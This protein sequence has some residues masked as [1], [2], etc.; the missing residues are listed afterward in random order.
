MPHPISIGPAQRCPGRAGPR[1][2][3]LAL[4]ALLLFTASCARGQATAP[5]PPV[6]FPKGDPWL[7][8]PHPLTLAD[9][10]GRI[11]LLDF[12]TPGCINCVQMLPV[13]AR[14]EAAHPHAFTVVEIDSPKFTDSGTLPAL[15][16]FLA[17][18]DVRAPVMLD[19][20]LRL[21]N[22]YG[23][24]AWP[25]Y[26]L[27]GADGHPRVAWLGETPYASLAQ[28]VD[29]QRTQ[30][31]A[32]HRLH[33]RPIRILPPRVPRGLLRWP[34]A[35]AVG[36]GLVAIADTT[37]NRILLLSPRGRLRA[38]IGDG[39]AG[40]RNGAPSVARF[41]HPEGVAFGRKRLYVADTGNN[42]IRTVSLKTLRVRTLAGTGT[43]GYARR[44]HGP[45]RA[46]AL[47]APWG[48]LRKGDALWIAMAGS[49]QVFRL[50]LK[51]D[52]IDLWA[53]DGDE[54]LR[55]G[56]RHRAQ[57]AQPTALAP[58]PG[59]GIF[60]ASPESSSIQELLPQKDQVRT[61]A[62]QGLFSW[63]D[64]D[65]PLA[66]ALFQHPQG[67]ASAGGDLYVADTFNGAIRRIDLR[68]RNVRT[69]ATGLD[70]PEGMAWLRPGVLLIAETG[71]SRLVTLTVANGAVHP[72]PIHGGRR[73]PPEH[74]KR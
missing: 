47:N 16:V 71:A 55:A 7:E 4:A 48:L 39:R 3:P 68:T 64:R 66:Q 22:A 63:G 15:K 72:W 12:F 20:G 62:G 32:A 17:A 28:A 50:N 43:L 51:T 5:I 14:L 73:A 52:E 31:L 57:F 45:A 38:V 21:W 40:V 70:M 44:A 1:I 11:V 23:V 56:P 58:A 29:H 25:T 6:P 35:V 9:L 34:G 2:G 42:L 67:L 27:L 49:H 61:V 26:V 36:D 18:H 37:A 41:A 46:I 19:Q 69:I 13:L 54:G 60:V 10:R 65:G 8:V 24:N 53:G 59:E 74:H 30:A 33:P